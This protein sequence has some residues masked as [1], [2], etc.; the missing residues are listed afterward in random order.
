MWAVFKDGV[1]ASKA[2]STKEAALIEGFEAKLIY[3]YYPDFL[4]DTGGTGMVNGYEVK[5]V[6][7]DTNEVS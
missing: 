4:G 2:H 5:E 1:Q 3:Q 7:E 6:K